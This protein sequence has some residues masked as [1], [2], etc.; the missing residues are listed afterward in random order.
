MTRTVYPRTL[1]IG[2]GNP[3]R[4]DDAFP[5]SAPAGI[6]S[7]RGA[8]TGVLRRPAA[9][10]AD[11]ERPAPPGRD[12][13]PLFWVAIPLPLLVRHFVV[14]RSD[15]P[16]WHEGPVPDARTPSAYRGV[17]RRT[18]AVPPLLRRLPAGGAARYPVRV[19]EP[20]VPGSGTMPAR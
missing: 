18:C 15:A 6:P 3:L 14:R 4:A 8:P 7:A 5:A 17:L 11:P 10:R 1:L 19:S 13:P 12:F 9:G 2:I 20:I 16:A